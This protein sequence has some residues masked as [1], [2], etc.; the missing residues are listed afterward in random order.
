MIQD[1]LVS[2]DAFAVISLL[3]F[4]CILVGIFLRA[5]LFILLYMRRSESSENGHTCQEEEF[6]GPASDVPA[7]SSRT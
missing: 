5:V 1:I 7:E 2:R 6:N 3:V 4:L